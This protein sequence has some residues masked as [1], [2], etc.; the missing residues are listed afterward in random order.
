MTEPAA[1]RTSFAGW[2]A[3]TFLAVTTALAWLALARSQSA[4]M[5]MT[6]AMDMATPPPSLSAK[7]GMWVAMT[8]AMMLPVAA[9]MLA[10]GG[11][12]AIGVLA[13]AAGYLG[14]WLGFALA[15]GSAETLLTGLPPAPRLLVPAILAMVGAY[16]ISPWKRSTLSA[17]RRTAGELGATHPLA[18]T[19]QGARFAV[20]SLGSCAPLMIA[21]AAA[22]AMGLTWT[23]ALTVWLVV[24][25]EFEAGP[26]AA[27]LGG[28]LLLA[29]AAGLAL[30]WISL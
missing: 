27:R 4:G 23:L 17:C 6:G 24:E 7:V 13:A 30:G 25:T 12:G 21:F 22:G 20:V 18:A 3:L 14:P 11:R 28:A 26:L 15:A 8:V 16:Q 9:R 1:R 19:G 29:S 2:P 5:V 10:R